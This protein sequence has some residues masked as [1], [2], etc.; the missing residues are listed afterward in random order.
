[1]E[2]HYISPKPGLVPA[3]PRYFPKLPPSFPLFSIEFQFG[4]KVSP[5]C[6]MWHEFDEVGWDGSWRKLQR[7]HSKRKLS[8]LP[9][10][11]EEA[12][13]KTFP[14]SFCFPRWE[15]SLHLHSSLLVIVVQEFLKSTLISSLFPGIFNSRLVNFKVVGMMISDENEAF[16][17]G[18]IEDIIL[19]V[20]DTKFAFCTHLSWLLFSGMNC[21]RVRD[22]SS[23]L[24][25]I[26]FCLKSRRQLTFF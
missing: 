25:F 15:L 2:L 22:Q 19:S 17:F 13:L 12:N 10:R 16:D 1:M 21:G 20:F 26:D 3:V 23:E 11:K 5:V 9:K 7:N 6:N 14:V 24:K 8:K 18:V 4:E